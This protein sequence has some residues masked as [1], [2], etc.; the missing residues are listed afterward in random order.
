MYIGD[1]ET[2]MNERVDSLQTQL[3]AL[4]AQVEANR[5]NITLLSEQ[6]KLQD[7]LIATLAGS[8]AK[9]VERVEQNQDDVEEALDCWNRPWS[10]Q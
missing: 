6:Q 3:D 7:E 4:D 1:I 2:L 10:L 8:V 5:G 9:L